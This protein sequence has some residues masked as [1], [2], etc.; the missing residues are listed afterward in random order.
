V[1]SILF[2]VVQLIFFLS[3]N[4][5]LNNLGLKVRIS[6]SLG[7]RQSHILTPNIVIN[8]VKFN[9]TT[10]VSNSHPKC[11]DQCYQVFPDSAGTDSQYSLELGLAK[12][13]ALHA[14]E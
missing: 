3:A 4:S 5:E 8:D 7:Q 1:K 2:L 9:S 11:R 12:L 6:T 10:P 13:N 14:L